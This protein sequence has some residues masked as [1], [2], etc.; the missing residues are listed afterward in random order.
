LHKHLRF[1]KSSDPA[2]PMPEPHPSSI[3]KTITREALNTSLNHKSTKAHPFDTTSTIRKRITSTRRTGDDQNELPSPNQWWRPLIQTSED[4]T[5]HVTSDTK[6]CE[7]RYPASGTNRQTCAAMALW[8]RKVD[9][10]SWCIWAFGISNPSSWQS[11]NQSLAG[12]LAHHLRS[13]SQQT[14]GRIASLT[15]HS[16]NTARIAL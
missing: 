1:S 7:V 5:D 3:A 2:Y 13:L 9:L 14:V 4:D 12:G 6:S 8:N 16:V 10:E 11:M 15:T